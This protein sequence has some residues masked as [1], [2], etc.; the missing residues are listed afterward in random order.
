MN[1]D[2]RAQLKAREI[3][4]W[5][6]QKVVQWIERQL[7][8]HKC[9][10]LWINLI[11]WEFLGDFLFKCV[12]HLNINFRKFFGFDVI[13]EEV[14]SIESRLKNRFSSFVCLVIWIL[15]Y[16]TKKESLK[17]YYWIQMKKIANWFSD[18]TKEVFR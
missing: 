15:K 13:V 9:H 17:K 7:V 16:I 14:F 18:K 10:R 2:I 5:D 11:V 4:R 12:T 6:P 8:A 1:L 3:G